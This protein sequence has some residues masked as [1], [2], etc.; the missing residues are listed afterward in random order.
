MLLWIQ[1]TSIPSQGYLSG[2]C[3][4]KSCWTVRFGQVMPCDQGGRAS[5]EAVAEFA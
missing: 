1:L 3:P 4:S 2:W 5:L